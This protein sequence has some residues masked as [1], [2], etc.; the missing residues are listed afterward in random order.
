MSDE[1]IADHAEVFRGADGQWYV[2]TVSST[3]KIILRSDGYKNE[4][5]AKAVAA[6]TGLPVAVAS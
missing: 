1:K 2:R 5:W 4:S 6:D 3:G